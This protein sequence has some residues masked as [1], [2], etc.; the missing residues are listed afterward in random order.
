MSVSYM[1]VI[2]MCKSE[3][4]HNTA[5]CTRHM[6]AN[7]RM[8]RERIES[9]KKTSKSGKQ[10][11]EKKTLKIIVKGKNTMLFLH[12][13]NSNNTITTTRIIMTQND[14]TNMDSV[15]LTDFSAIEFH[16]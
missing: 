16:F 15:E 7:Y 11:T 5:E 10:K 8:K 14:K 9:I 12:N 3:L 2:R 1:T 6:N 13:N 4:N